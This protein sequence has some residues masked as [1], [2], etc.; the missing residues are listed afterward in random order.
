MH[1]YVKIL[2]FENGARISLGCPFYCRLV[3]DFEKDSNLTQIGPPTLLGRTCGSP[4]MV[5]KEGVQGF[6]HAFSILLGMS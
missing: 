1:I 6:L 3:L 5:A 2:N 4:M